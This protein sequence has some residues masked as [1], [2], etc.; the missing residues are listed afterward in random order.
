LHRSANS[1]NRGA[2]NSAA[3]HIGD[4]SCPDYVPYASRNNT[5][6]TKTGSCGA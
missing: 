1:A 2:N 6:G 3:D 4:K 5:S